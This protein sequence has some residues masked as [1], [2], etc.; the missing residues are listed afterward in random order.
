MTGSETSINAV[1]RALDIV[2]LFHQEK[3]E[4]GISEI[5]RLLGMHKSTVHRC[6]TTLE[7]KGFVQQNTETNRYWLGIK[8]YILGNLFR[9]KMRIQDIAAPFARQ[10]AEKLNET[11]HLAILEDSVE[12]GPQAVV[13][14][15]VETGQ[16]LS[17]TPR[18]GS[19][20]PA[21]CCGVGKVLLAYG[22]PEV[23]Q[24][25]AQRPLTRFTANTITEMPRL[26]LELERVRRNGF[27][28][29][30]DE[31]EV[32]LT[33]IAAPVFNHANEV[34]AAVST[35]GPTARMLPIKEE[36]VEEVKKSAV[37]ISQKLR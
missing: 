6:L 11:V 22:P 37:E 10:L 17:T 29:D 4:L 30:M 31:L 25:M 9:D 19:G 32:G 18:I 34:V 1:D 12:E 36:I 27:C 26:L 7:R 24:K 3:R 2:M 28:V 16:R 21:H 15:K 14:Y 33:C 8:F 13:I 5:S 35:S 20:A 23:L